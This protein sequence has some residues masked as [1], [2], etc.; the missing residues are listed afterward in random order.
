MQIIDQILE[1][2][3][4]SLVLMTLA[5]LG[6]FLAVYVNQLTH[7][8]AEDHNDPW[9]IRMMRNAAYMMLAWGFL[10]TL[11]YAN[12]KG[13]QPW[14][15]VILIIVAVDIILFN[16]ALAIKA[17]IRRIGVGYDSPR[18]INARLAKQ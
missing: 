13:W 15:P 2:W 3:D 11:S 14:P 16:R 17:H 1:D 6:F 8:E 10:W 12:A 7:Y 18:A 4:L 9:F 5:M